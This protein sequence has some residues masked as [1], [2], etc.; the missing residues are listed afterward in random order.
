MISP[1]IISRLASELMLKSKSTI[2]EP[3]P[4]RILSSFIDF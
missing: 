2:D 4:G 1:L 3:D